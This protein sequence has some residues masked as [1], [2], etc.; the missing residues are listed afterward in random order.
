LRRVGVAANCGGD[1]A[2]VID[3]SDGD[4]D[5]DVRC[6]ARFDQRRVTAPPGSPVAAHD[7]PSDA[8]ASA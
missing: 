7:R 5:G 4:G 1:G 2:C 6:L 8:S 3:R